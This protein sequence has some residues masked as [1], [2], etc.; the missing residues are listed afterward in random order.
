LPV[1]VR[2]YSTLYVRTAD[3]LTARARIRAAA[4]ELFGEQGFGVGLRAIADR[5]GVSLGLIRHHFGSKDELRA[6]CDRYVLDELE[7]I[8][9]AKVGADDPVGRMLVNVRDADEVSPLVGYLVRGLQSGGAL[10]TAFLERLIADSASALADGVES[11]MIKPSV[12]PDARARFL[13]LAL[14][15]GLLLEYSLAPA[16]EDPHVTWRRFADEAT[17]PGL[18]LYTQGLLTDREMLDAYL[19]YVKD[20]PADQAG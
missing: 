17:L 20:P 2:A 4:V 1:V 12:D 5:A 11:G 9:Q 14:V 6:E 8:Q 13:V 18:E 19:D 16:G 3:D 7:R 10:A 15:G